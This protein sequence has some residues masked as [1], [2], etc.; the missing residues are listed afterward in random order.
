VNPI[1]NLPTTYTL[2][3]DPVT[4]EGWID[5]ILNA[6]GDRRIGPASGP[7]NMEPGDTQEVVV[8][9][10]CAGAIPGMDAKSAV[11]LNYLEKLFLIGA[12]T[13]QRLRQLSHLIIRDISSRD[14]MYTSYHPPRQMYLLVG[15]WQHLT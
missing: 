14:T 15:D 12:R 1:T 9:E 2:S 7:F 6:P 10:I 3:G 4:G 5:G 8:A 13:L 11:T